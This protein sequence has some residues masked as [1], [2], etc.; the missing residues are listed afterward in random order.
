MSN[1]IHFNIIDQFFK[2]NSLVE[3]HI[4][5]VNYFYDNDI[6]KILMDLNPITYEN[7][8]FESSNTYKNTM[9]VYFGGI[10]GSKIYYGKPII[11]ENGKQKFLYPNEAR[12]RNMTYSIS[13]HV[14]IDVY[15]TTYHKISNTEIDLQYP[16]RYK[17]T[18]PKYYLGNFPIMLNSNLCILSGLKQN[19]KYHIGECYH[20]YG[21]YFIIDGKE[22]ALIPQEAFANNMMYIRKVKDNIHDFSVE[23]RSISEN[24]SKPKRTLAI[25]R[26]AMKEKSH[27]EYFRVFVPNIR[28]DVPLFILFRALG[29]ESDK[30]ILRIILGKHMNNEELLS[31]LRPS[32]TDSGEIYTQQQAITFLHTFIKERNEDA[33]YYILSDYF[34]PH[35]GEM[36]FRTKAYYLGYMV[37]ELMKTILGLKPVTDRDHYKFKRVETSGFLMKELFSEYANIM[38]KEFYVNIEKLDYFNKNTYI[39]GEDFEEFLRSLPY[40]EDFLTLE[41]TNNQYP[42]FVDLLKM[43]HSSLFQNKT[44]DIGFRKAFKGNW[45][46]FSHTKRLGVIQELNRLSYNSFLSH[47]RKL[48]L[49]IDASAKIVGPHMLHGTQ[50]GIIDPVDT[51]DG[52]NVGFHKH[53]AMTCKVTHKMDQN[54]MYDWI[55]KNAHHKLPM[56]NANDEVKMIPIYIASL[57]QLEEYVKVFLN[58]HLIGVTNAPMILKAKIVFA[59]RMNLIPI[60]VSVTHDITDNYLHIWCDEGRLLRPLLHFVNGKVSYEH[61]QDI[62]ERIESNTYSWEDMIYARNVTKKTKGSFNQDFVSFDEANLTLNDV[63]DM[64]I[65]DFLDKSEEESMYLCSSIE[66]VNETGNNPYTHMDI[67]PSLLLGVMGNMVIFPEHNQLPRDLFSCGQSKQAVS[68]YHSNYHN[69]IDKMG[70]VLNYG[71]IPLVRSKYLDYINESK[72][73]YG[74]NT[75]VAI[76]C[77]TSYNVEDSILFNKGSIDRGLFQTTYYNSYQTREES[78]DIESGGQESIIKNVLEDDIVVTKPGYDYNYL[79]ERGVIKENTPMTDNKVIIGKMSYNVNNIDEKYD[80]S[81]YPKKGQIGYVDKTYVSTGEEG[82]RLAKVRMREQRIPAIGDKF[83]SRCGQKGTVG[84]IIPEENMPFTKDGVRP[85]IIINPHAIPSRMTIGQLV[86][87]VMSKLGVHLGSSMD[88]TAFNTSHDKIKIISELLSENDYHSTGEEVLYNAMTGEQIETSFFMGPTYYMRLKHMV[89]DKINYRAQGPRTLLTR[90]TNH[91]RANDGGLRI[92]E[93]ERDGVISHGCSKFLQDSMMKRGDEYTAAVCN[94][95]GSLAVYDSMQNQFFSHMVDG[96][97]QFDQEANNTLVANKISKKGKEFSVVKI[98]Y[99][100]KLLMQELTSMNVHMRLITENNVSVRDEILKSSFTSIDNESISNSEM[101]EKTLAKEVQQDAIDETKLESLEDNVVYDA[102]KDQMKP[103]S[104]Y[105]EER[106]KSDMAQDTW[107]RFDID[108]ESDSPMFGFTSIIMD[109]QGDP[110]ESLTSDMEY[111]QQL[112]GQSPNIYPEGW[113]SK[114][115]IEEGITAKYMID[116]LKNNIDIADNWNLIIKKL[117]EKKNNIPHGIDTTPIVIPENEDPM[118]LN[119]EEL[120]DQDTTEKN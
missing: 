103:L 84:T 97:I 110:T 52:G 98:P 42:K 94:H 73:P 91:G 54:K 13:I 16:H 21:G 7:Q 53:M 28:K 5:S 41:E 39:D 19:E 34:L 40:N 92:G 58:G 38:Y 79:D 43:N 70:V 115:L 112:E 82:E 106:E 23:I 85:D 11:N 6:R 36:N 104:H 20:D 51:P 83:C 24:E 4:K 72:H 105:T 47:L 96:P 111:V 80:A 71:E 37:F 68:L 65:L 55:F 69:R 114:E 66:S 81:V 118:G 50:W 27:N 10:D 57:S 99:S 120:E 100:F 59:R 62:K 15:V 64:S 90:Q 93:M 107:I 29:I 2:S 77:H 25:R 76:M 8:L 67:H 117:N 1:E 44:I 89:K 95:S 9:Q 113:N 32:I 74:H 49:N 17:F 48:N 116:A 61:N 46:A 87:T 108:D 26:V 12:L 75:I 18:I 35:L 30:E 33:M 56:I 78:S 101:K 102:V 63:D 22:K 14:D 3:H 88:S 109:P 86:E 45:G 60:F 119:I 31:M